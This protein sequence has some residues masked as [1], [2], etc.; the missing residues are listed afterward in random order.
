MVRRTRNSKIREK[1]VIDRRWS[2]EPGT[3]KL[4]RECHWQ[5]VVRRTRNSEIRE[6][7]VLECH[8]QT[9]VRRTRNS[10]IREKNVIGRWWSGEQGTVKLG[11][12]M[13]LADGGQE[14]KEK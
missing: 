6:K 10:K 3:V 13:S 4:G 5:T 1:N 14:N 7:N 12:R 2:G 11:R 8:W 9:V